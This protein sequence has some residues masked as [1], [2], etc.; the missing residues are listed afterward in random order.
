MLI[1]QA[2]PLSLDVTEHKH[3]Y[4]FQWLAQLQHTVFVLVVNNTAF[5]YN[6]T[7]PYADVSTQVCAHLRLLCWIDRQ[8]A[9][10]LVD[11]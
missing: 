11:R 3:T 6:A 9:Q 10:T 2:R 5:M 7:A 8:A 4:A 1:W